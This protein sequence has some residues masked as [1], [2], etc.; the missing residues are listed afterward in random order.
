MSDGGGV[1]R[2]RRCRGGCCLVRDVRQTDAR[3]VVILCSHKPVLLAYAS[4]LHP[5]KQSDAFSVSGSAP[6]GS[7]LASLRATRET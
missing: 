5:R 4:P 2:G 3:L 6:P 1:G 7:R